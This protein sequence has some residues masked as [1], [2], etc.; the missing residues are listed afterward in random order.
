MKI[1]N[2]IATKK[3]LYNL[4]LAFIENDI[5]DADDYQILFP[6]NIQI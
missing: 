4:L 5:D 6:Q 2:Y 1:H 3:E